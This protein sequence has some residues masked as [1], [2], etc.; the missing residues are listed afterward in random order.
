MGRFSE[1][2]RPIEHWIGFDRMTMMEQRGLVPVPA[3]A[4][5]DS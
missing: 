1:D 5:T 2:G 3:G 4:P